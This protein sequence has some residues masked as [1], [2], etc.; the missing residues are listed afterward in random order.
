MR[1]LVAAILVAAAATTA[2]A[3]PLPAGTK[4][5]IVK[6]RP[7]VKQGA[8][9]VPLLDDDRQGAGT[10]I[11]ATLSDDGASIEASWDRCGMGDDPDSLEQL[12][13]PLA[14]VT[15]RLENVAGMGLHLKKKYAAA[16][17]HFVTAAAANPDEPMF[18]TNLLSAQSMAGKLDDADRT[19]ATY[20]P[21]NPAWFVWRLAVDPELKAVKARPA[22]LALAAAKPGTME[23]S[24]LDK[25]AGW[26]AVGGGLVATLE[27]QGDGGPGAPLEQDLVIYD[28]G[29]HRGVLRLPLSTAAEECDVSP[30][31][32]CG[33]D[34]M[35]PRCTQKQVAAIAARAKVADAL[36][37][38]LGFAVLPG[39]MAETPL[40]DTATEVKAPDGKSKV[41]V[42]QDKLHVTVGGKSFDVDR[43]ERIDHVI[44]VKDQVL[45]EVSERHIFFCDDDSFR[46]TLRLAA[47]SS[48]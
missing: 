6:N 25:S 17:P 4:V 31:D 29:A 32:P 43:E 12:S 35:V 23:V 44:F 24:E 21:R 8:L 42:T 41:A 9:T 18:A 1:T 38:S 30:P 33:G 19:L 39:A 47:P 37:A 26:S 13:V 2:A 3:K 5:V 22:A 34:S 45:L 46:S 48:P 15:A 27:Y 40:D 10:K 20:G 28:L 16:I 7:M 36:L 11:T 14:H